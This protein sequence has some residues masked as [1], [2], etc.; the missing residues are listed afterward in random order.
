MKTLD[1]SNDPSDWIW[2]SWIATAQGG[3]LLVLQCSVNKVNGKRQ[4]VNSGK[5]AN[6][7]ETSGIHV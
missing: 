4:H 2:R 6:C 1:Y 7:L 5:T 3:Y